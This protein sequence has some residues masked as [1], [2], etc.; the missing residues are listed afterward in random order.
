MA[1]IDNLV[2]AENRNRSHIF[3]EAIDQ[4]LEVQNYHTSLIQRGL[5]DSEEGKTL[6]HRVVGRRLARQRASCDPNLP[7]QD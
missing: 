2:G 7:I 6:S 1:N 4:C 3:N 5:W